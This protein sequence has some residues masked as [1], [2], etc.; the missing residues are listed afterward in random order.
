MHKV[1]SWKI[2][3]LFQQFFLNF[4]FTVAVRTGTIVSIPERYLSLRTLI[5]Y[6][7]DN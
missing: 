5:I 3:G 6:I 7:C 1:L 4:K 2:T